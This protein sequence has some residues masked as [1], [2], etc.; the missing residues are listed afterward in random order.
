MKLLW[1]QRK[2]HQALFGLAL[3]WPV[4]LTFAQQSLITANWM[5]KTGNKTAN[6]PGVYGSS[7]FGSPQNSPSA[8]NGH[9]MVYDGVQGTFYVFGGWGY[10]SEMGK[11]SKSK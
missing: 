11:T 10:G 8:R 7:T 3:L 1:T 9:S 2:S 4:H 5:W 6:S